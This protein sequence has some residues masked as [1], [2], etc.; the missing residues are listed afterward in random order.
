M[1]TGARTR[2]NG[3]WWVLAAIVWTLFVWVGRIRN[4]LADDQ[5]EGAA[6]IGVL[7]LCAS[8]VLP[9]LVLVA[10]LLRRR[11]EVGSLSVWLARGLLVWSGAFWLWRMGEMVITG[12]REPAFVAVHAVLGVVSVSL[13]ALALRAMSLRA[14]SLR[15]RSLWGVTG[16]SVIE[17]YSEQIAPSS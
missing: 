7:V 2:W 11:G 12:G 9:T 14:R 8:F 13:W 10:S 15:A 1:Q 4:V 5:T 6:R 3:R 16:S 17:G